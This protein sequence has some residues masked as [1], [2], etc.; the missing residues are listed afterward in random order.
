M[1]QLRTFKGLQIIAAAALIGAA[2]IP[3]SAQSSDETLGAIIGGAAG[4]Y[5]GGKVD[6]KDGDNTEGVIAGA[7]IGGTLGYIIG[8]QSDDR[9]RR[10]R[11]RYS[12]QRGEFYRRNGQAYRR[13]NDRDE[14][15]VLIRIDNNDPYYYNDGRSRGKKKGHYKNGKR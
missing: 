8:S 13:Y 6:N 3:A 5:I 12:N 7:A 2:A 1:K 11:E 15:I 10:L 9:D 4:A 14:G